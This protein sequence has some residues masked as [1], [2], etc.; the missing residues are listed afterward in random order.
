MG[1]K[2]KFDEFLINDVVQMFSLERNP[3]N[4][5]IIHEY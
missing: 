2:E 3:K 5:N 1:I 4:K